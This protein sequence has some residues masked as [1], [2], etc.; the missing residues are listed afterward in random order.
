MLKNFKLHE[1]TGG[2]VRRASLLF[3]TFL[4]VFEICVLKTDYP[5]HAAYLYQS[6]DA[7]YLLVSLL[8]IGIALYCF[9]NFVVV[10]FSSG[11]KYR[12]LYLVFFSFAVFY[13]YGYHKAFGRDSDFPDIDAA[14]ATTP[15]QKLSSIL[16]Y[17]SLA[18]LVPCIVFVLF[19]IR[20]KPPQK[21]QGFKG[22][23]TIILLFGVFFIHLAYVAE[24]FMEKKFPT[25][26]MNAFVRTQSDYLVWGSLL[27]ANLKVR[28]TLQ[29]PELA[30]GFRPANNIVLVVDESIR[31][32]HLSINGYER[33][34][35][36]FLEELQAKGILKNW[37]IA[38]SAATSSQPTYDILITG[39]LPGDLPDKS[40]R[41]LA[42]SP[43]IFQYAKAMNYT[44][45]FFDGQM[46]DYWGGSPDDKNYIDNWVGYLKLSAGKPMEEWEIDARFAAEVN[47]I[48]SGS[49]GNFIFVFKRGNHIPYHSNYP[50]DAET[51]KP[52]YKSPNA[53]EI[54]SAE[55][56]Q[57]IVN[58][59]DNVLKYNLDSFF[60]NMVAD[61]TKLPN[62]TVILYTGDHGQTFFTGGRASH[63]GNSKEEATVPLFIIGDLGERIDT[64]YKASHQNLLPTILDL[65]KFPDELRARKYG[66]SLIGA[67]AADSEPRFYN[68]LS[69]E[70]F[71]FD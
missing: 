38:S 33:K 14:M 11:W 13:E 48:I 63:G 3:F 8:Y 60:K 42:K 62:D 64:N 59:Y 32:D 2:E 28:D 5:A 23:L 69:G 27:N 18:S 47:K 56:Y 6:N 51:W 55:N 34:T 43:S 30:E 15:E 49:T 26:S 17:F 65:I 21:A 53:F 44:T 70:K 37:G 31:G 7:S 36:P 1:K 71:P 35:T 22:L 66:L 67:T 57:A 46:R 20:F 9:F 41:T 39:A 16:M 50:A 25:V 10:T 40:G 45:H 24:I 52:A 19:L 12:A 58:S 68:P 61:Y 29:K 4:L 54:P